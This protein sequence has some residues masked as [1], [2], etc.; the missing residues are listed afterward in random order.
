MA[1]DKQQL[2]G[3]VRVQPSRNGLAMLGG[4]GLA[5]PEK[6]WAI[7]RVANR[8]DN[9][10]DNQLSRLLI[11]HWMPLRKADSNVG[12]R[13]TGSPGCP[14]WTLAWEGYLC[15]K[16]EDSA[17]AWH[18]LMAVKH[19]RTVLGFNGRP[20]FMSDDKLLSLKAEVA[21]LKPSSGKPETLFIE[22]EEI[23]VVDG[24]FASFPGKIE[25]LGTGAKEGRARVE[26]LI[27]GRAVPV[28]LDLA[29]LAKRV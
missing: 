14:V 13:R 15:V 8:R 18:E 25:K 17:E 5:L 29:Q 3:A 12:G 9:D 6:R 28:E 23:I 1:T 16:M 2:S 20:F 11:D 22:G 24:S 7:V 21:T 27:F 4:A 10:V 19:V 26:V